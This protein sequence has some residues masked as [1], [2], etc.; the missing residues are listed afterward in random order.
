MV[1]TLGLALDNA[2]QQCGWQGKVQ[3]LGVVGG[4]SLG[5]SIKRQERPVCCEN[6][7]VELDIPNK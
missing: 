6:E 5:A 3:I 1:D 4:K 7:K 2:T